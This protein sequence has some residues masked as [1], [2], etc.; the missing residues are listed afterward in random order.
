MESVHKVEQV[1]NPEDIKFLKELME[2]SKQLGETA[3]VTEGHLDADVVKL[4]YGTIKELK[5][6]YTVDKLR[7]LKDVFGCIG[8]EEYPKK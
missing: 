7:M 4:Y 3:K 5:E 2:A 6:I 1:T 8:S